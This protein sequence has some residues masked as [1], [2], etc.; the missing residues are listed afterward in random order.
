MITMDDFHKTRALRHL[1][2]NYSEIGRELGIDRKTARRYDQSQAPPRYSPRQAPSR[3]DLFAAFESQVRQWLEDAP[4]ISGAE[5]Y[6][7]LRVRGYEGSERTVERRMKAMK[8]VRPKER[9]FEQEYV[10]GEQSQFDFK[11]SLKLPFG[12]GERLAHLHFGTLPYSDAF[13]IHAYPQKTYECFMDGVH[14]FFEKIGGMTENIRFDNLSPCVK[15][16][17]PSSKRIYTQSF[18]RAIKYYGFGLLPCS[19][20]KGSDKGDVERDIQTWSRRFLNHVK[21]HKIVFRDFMQLNEEL[22]KFCRR[23]LTGEKFE[24][25]QKRLKPLLPR[26]QS[27]L[28]RIEESRA[29]SHGTVIVN[30][31]CY[32]VPDEWIGEMCRAVMGPFETHLARVG[33][34][35]NVIVHPRKPE[36]EHSIQLEHVIKSLVRKPQA[37]VRWA[38][39][40]I[41]FPDPVFEKLYA[42]LNP[43][44]NEP[45]GFR[46][47]EFLKIIN[48]VH[49]TQL[50]EIKTA[51]EIVLSQSCLAPEIFEFVKDLIFTERRP[52]IADVTD[53]HRSSQIPLEPNLSIYDQLIPKAALP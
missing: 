8:D 39:R 19:P 44:E 22:T 17:L 21:V 24:T 23:E 45:P 2:K 7:L 1:G 15:K 40:E 34:P 3:A 52:L 36:G 47:R 53:L 42:S 10:P 12:E 9:F 51:V 18:E 16:V 13:F 20:G 48:L 4:K 6:A 14:S 41:L 25:E 37:M 28:C 31:T 27:V 5:I 50:S 29:S 46:E 11:E 38:H 33:S 26:D 30:R 32:S 43:G 35:R 49:H